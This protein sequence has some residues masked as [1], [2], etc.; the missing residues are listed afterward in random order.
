MYPAHRKV[1]LWLLRKVPA[2]TT[3]WTNFRL[4][5]RYKQRQ[6]VID[7]SFGVEAKSRLICYYFKSF[8]GVLQILR[9]LLN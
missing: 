1:G 2:A 6:L 9:L 4:T 5:H 8:D 7:L 3:G